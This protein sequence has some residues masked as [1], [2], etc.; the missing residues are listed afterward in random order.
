LKTASETCPVSSNAAGKIIDYRFISRQ[1]IGTLPSRYGVENGWRQSRLN[2]Q[3][4]M[5]VE[6]ELR[7]PFPPGQADRQLVQRRRNRAA[8]PH[9]GTDALYQ[10]A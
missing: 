1:A 2:R 10:V 7:H 3:P 9:I 6:L 8:E 4:A 5:R